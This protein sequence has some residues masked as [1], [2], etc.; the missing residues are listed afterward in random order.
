VNS[1]KEAK[2]F[3]LQ[4]KVAER[5]ISRPSSHIEIF[6]SVAKAIQIKRGL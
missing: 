4:I 6:G 2:N 1:F 5:R 3:E